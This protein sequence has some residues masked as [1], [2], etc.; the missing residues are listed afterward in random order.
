[1]A[2]HT[3]IG[4][5]LMNNAFLLARPS[6]G[7]VGLLLGRGS[8]SERARRAFPI[9]V[10]TP[11][12]L[13]FAVLE[14]TQDG[15]VAPFASREIA[16]SLYPYQSIQL[17]KGDEMGRFKLGSTAIILFAKDKVEWSKKYTAGTPTKMGEIMGRRL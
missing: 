12:G 3:A 13:C 10:I 14:M 16:T 9:I 8:G 15:Q 4:F 5:L 17:K 2:L 7:W 6:V 1:M 11:I